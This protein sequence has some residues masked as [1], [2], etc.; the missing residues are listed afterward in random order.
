MKHQEQIFPAS[1]WL[2]LDPES[3]HGLTI[4][5]GETDSGK[6]TLT[7]WLAQAMAATRAPTAWIDGDIGQSC[8]GVPS[9]MNL[10]FMDQN[11]PMPPKVK[12]SYFIGST[13]AAGN[14]LPIVTGLK[15]LVERALS[16]L[17]RKVILD[18]TGFV[19]VASGGLELKKWK[20][21]LLQPRTVISLQ[22]D[23]ELEPVLTPLR[24][25]TRIRII[26]IALSPRTR[27]KS[28][29]QRVRN[30]RKKFQEYFKDAREVN[31]YIP[32]LPVYDLHLARRLSLM[33]LLDEQGFCLA[34]GSV[35]DK[36][37]RQIKIA[38]P[39]KDQDGVAGLRVGRIRID[40]S[41]GIELA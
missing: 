36:T 20:I 40:P 34:L 9:T 28:R 39:W 15:R 7:R 4:M 5:L 32:D 12:T 21:E 3:L 19:A 25:Q 35:L 14:F 1:E 29:E 23:N 26:D 6:T 41:T 10:A 16:S 24:K 30:R 13:N 31:F 27:K 18:T 33:G 38:T 8:L 37:D 22:R 17:E 11:S 2:E